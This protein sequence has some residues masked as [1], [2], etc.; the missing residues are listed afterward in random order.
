M[1]DTCNVK[2]P[3]PPNEGMGSEDGGEWGGGMGG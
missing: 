1:R 3:V 2:S